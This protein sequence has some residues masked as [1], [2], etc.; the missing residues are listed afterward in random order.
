MKKQFALIRV[1]ICCKCEHG[2]NNL[3]LIALKNYN[4]LRNSSDTYQHLLN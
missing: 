1:L 3:Y 2:F 4:D